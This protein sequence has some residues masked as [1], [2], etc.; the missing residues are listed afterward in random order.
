M[1]GTT[2]ALATP[3]D[4]LHRVFGFREFRPLQQQVIE[5]VIAGGDAFVLMPTGGGKSLCYQIPALHRPGTAVVVS[6]LISLMKDQVDAL[7]EAGVAAAQ[8]NSSL[9]AWEAGEVLRGLRAGELDLLYVA[10]ERLVMPTFLAL[11]DRVPLALFAVDE[12]HCV[13]QWGHDFRPEYVELGVLR[14]RFPGVPLIALTATADEQTRGDVREKLGLAEAGV[15]I[16]GFDRPNIRYLV[17]EKRRPVEQLEA[18]LR[19]RRD[20]S[21]IVYCLSRR[22]VEDVAAKLRAAG[23][24]AAPYHAGLPA[25]ERT[26]VQDAFQRDEVRV[27]VATVAFGLGIDKSNVRF[28]VH[29]DMP[30]SI[31]SYYQETGRAGR[32]GLHADALLLYGLGDVATARALIESGSSGD[33]LRIDLHKLNAMVGFAEAVSCRR[34]ALLGYFGETPEVDCGNCDVCLDPPELYDG[35]EDAQKALSCVYRLGQRFGLVHVVDVLRGGATERIRTLGHDRLSTY[36]C[37][38]DHSREEW[39]SL[40]RQLIHKGY[41]RQDIGQYSVLKLTVAA[42]PVL[43]GDERVQ[44]ARPRVFIAAPAERRSRT[45]RPAGAEVG[46]GRTDMPADDGSTARF[47]RLRALRRRLADEH[48]VPAYVIFSDA[49]LWEMASVVPRDD[50]ELLQIN[51]V[52]QTKLERYG[53]AFLEAILAK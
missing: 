36:G 43:R 28:V 2:A 7:R 39:M 30:K 13:S 8:L 19:G 16:A 14:T 37:G 31:E 27:V 20:E 47:E 34:R 40:L 4:T 11:L 18:F 41:L 12:A 38:M 46:S 32:D 10:P 22:R 1:T 51:G 6:P 23:L 15:F 49:T 44:L 26:A 24:A 35:T 53:S 21:G 45:R 29:Y 48:A 25:E 50:V 42:A 33:Q 5:H 52:G 17:A 3:A 9:D